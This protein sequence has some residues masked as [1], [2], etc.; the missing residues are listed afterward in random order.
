MDQELK[1]KLNIE[2]IR[3]NIVERL[4]PKAIPIFLGQLLTTM[5]TE[6]ID[7]RTPECGVCK[8]TFFQKSGIRKHIL[9]QS[10]EQQKKY[11]CDRCETTNEGSI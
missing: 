11:P 1:G 10:E 4:D 5:D 2:Q 9:L 7:H 6:S 3:V 8:Q